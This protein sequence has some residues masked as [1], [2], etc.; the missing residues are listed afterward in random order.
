MRTVLVTGGSGYIAGYCIADLLNRGDRVRASIRSISREAE[1]RSALAKLSDGGDR[2][3]FHA[4][5]LT[6]D[7]GW[8]EAVAGCDGVLHVASPFYATT[9]EAEM[10]GPAR[11]GA[12]RVLRAA[13]DAGVERVVLTSSTQACSYPSQPAPEPWDE[14]VWS[15]PTR[16]EVNAYGRSKTLAERAAWD[17]VDREGARSKLSVVCPGA[18]FGPVLGRDYSFSL[19]IVERL[20]KGAMPGL[21]RV[22]FSAVDVRDVADLHLRCLDDPAAAGERFIGVERFYWF[23]DIAQMLRR[24]LGPDAAKVPTR[25]IPSIFVR[26]LGLVDKEVRSLRGD[27][28]VRRAHTSAKAQDRLGWR[29]RPMPQTLVDTARSLKAEGVV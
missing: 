25:E 13:L 1:V 6:A 21:P 12:L 5:D 18:N 3:T 14:S 16:S 4:A 24:E 23:S 20:L 17:F 28:D 9:N 8:A 2:L 15:D 26:A 27:L 11:D 7:A 29:P 19:T 10:V 22:G